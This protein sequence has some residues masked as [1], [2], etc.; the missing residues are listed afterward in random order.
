MSEIFDTAPS[1]VDAG[2]TWLRRTVVGEGQL[3]G[4]C[5]TLEWRSQCDNPTC[6]HQVYLMH[7]P[8]AQDRFLGIYPKCG[9][10]FLNKP[11]LWNRV[12]NMAVIDPRCYPE[13]YLE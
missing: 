3:L 8:S 6:S 12:W 5:R 1:A 2:S 7:A 13:G 11:L 10:G 9:R 4:G